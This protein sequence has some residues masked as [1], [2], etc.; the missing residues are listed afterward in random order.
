MIG[1]PTTAARSRT[2]LRRIIELACR[3]PSVH[4][5][6]PWRWR[7]RGAELELHA[8]RSRQLQV[9]DPQ[10]RNLVISCG[11]ALHHAQ[12]AAGALGWE[13]RVDRVPFGTASTLLA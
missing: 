7:I 5:T 2:V 13:A 3:A 4:N 10:G 6:Q 12:V 8:D 1:L 11:A 9:G